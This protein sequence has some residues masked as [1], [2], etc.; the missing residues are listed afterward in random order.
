MNIPDRLQELPAKGAHLCLAVERF[1]TRELELPTRDQKALL[2]LSGGPDS[3]ALLVIFRVLAPRLGMSLVA[4]HLDHGIREE[5]PREAEF[6][7]G[8]C[9]QCGV[10][11]HGGATRAELFARRTGRGLEEAGRVLRYR[12]LAGVKD[13]AGAQYVISGHHLDDLAEDFLL[14]SLRGSGWP[15]ISGMAGYEPGLGLV[16]PLLATSKADLVQLL[17]DLDI[18]WQ[19]DSSNQ[20]S[21]FL[22][23]RVR[24]RILPQMLQENPRFPENVL[25]LWRMGNLEREELEQHLAE[26]RATERPLEQGWLLPEPQLR[27]LGGATRTRWIKDALSRLGPGQ[28]RSRNLLR[29]ERAWREKRLGA[30]IQ[31]PG[32]KRARIRREGILLSKSSRLRNP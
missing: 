19:E 16:R 15:E 30:E 4:A 31:F 5:S 7:Q 21:K 14:R 9:R 13:K 1:L 12:F 26:L 29:L 8:L 3:T 28:A 11:L 2:S 25:Y 10:P 20:D 27:S 24:H 22:R 17:R 18:S 32:D 23:N 6:V